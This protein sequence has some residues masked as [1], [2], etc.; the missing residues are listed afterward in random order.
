MKFA[1]RVLQASPSATLALS[2]KAKQMVADGIDVINLGVGEPDFQTSAAIKQAAIKAIND[3]KADFY[4]PANGILP[5]RQAICDRLKADF[6]VTFQPDQVTVTVGGKFSLYVLAQTL[7][8]SGD[9]VLIPLPYWVSYGEQIKLAD[10]QPI[11]V[12]PKSSSKVTVAELESARTSKTRAVIIN[13]P[14]NPSG[15]VYSKAELMAIGEWA[16]EHDV[17]LLADDMYGKLVYNGNKFTSLIQLSEPIRRQT[18]LVSG[19]SKAYAMTG[20][21]IGYTVADQAVISKMNTIISHATSNLAAVSQYAALAA[22]TGDQSVV[23][24]MRQA[25]EQR[26]NTIYPELIAIPGFELPQ[27]PEGAFYLF[28]KV[29][30]AVKMAG[31]SST[32]EF[33]TALLEQAHVA[34]VAG[35]GF[36]MPDHLRLSYATDL[37]SLQTAIKRIKEFM[38]QFV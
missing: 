1:K 34:V 18:I 33:A 24:K 22:L 14:Q 12:Q 2:A 3:G 32:E 4:T 37:K 29:A 17:I 10:A 25:F 5:L 23:E 7:F 8:E 28:P 16:V 36:G 35:V 26:L 13:S 38:Q 30:A 19:L 31:F 20:W 6:G 9:E 15:L 27:K 21:R 11:F